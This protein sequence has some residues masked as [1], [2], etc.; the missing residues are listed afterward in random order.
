M[1]FYTIDLCRR[2]STT[3]LYLKF[4]FAHFEFEVYSWKECKKQ[5]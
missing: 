2:E 1:I 3:N 5:F 4:E